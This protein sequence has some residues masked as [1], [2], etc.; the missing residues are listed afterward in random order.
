MLHL[1]LEE[2]VEDWIRAVKPYQ[3]RVDDTDSDSARIFAAGSGFMELRPQ[4]LKCLFSYAFFFVSTDNAY[5]NL[6]EELNRANNDSCLNIKHDK[7]PR[8]TP[9]IEK[10]RLI[11]NISIAHFPA[12]PS[13]QV[14]ALDA[15]AAMDW[16]PMSMPVDDLENLLLDQGASVEQM[17]QDN[18]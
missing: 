14:S 16:M 5:G 11:R 2:V 10:I 4:F 13:K 8:D 18:A 17:P 9:F 12:K 1:I 15:Y 7:P 3:K 6:Y